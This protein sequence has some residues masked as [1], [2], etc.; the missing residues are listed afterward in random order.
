MS[1]V[2][3]TP[4][5]STHTVV[6]DLRDA[7]AVTAAVS[8]VQPSLVVHAAYARDEASI[9]AATQH[10]VDAAHGVGA[11]VLYVS[12]DAVF[13]G[14][15]IAR[16]E[17]ADPDPV[18]DY[19]RWKARAERIVSGGS[20]TAAIVRLPLIVSVEPDDPVVDRIRSTGAR[21]EQTA[22][23]QDETRQPALAAEM[24]EAVWGIA[25]LEPA[26]RAGPWHLPGPE[27]LSRY[28][29]ARR[30]VTTL[31]LDAD[32]IVAER[33]PPDAERPRHLKLRDGRARRR[34][35]WSPSRILS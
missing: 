19:G 2:H 7:G 30:V 31:G 3:R 20:Q 23:F 9:V 33:T 34:L 29:I 28:E 26:E 24:A 13:C 15:G 16:D 14:D 18:W 4:V 1:I 11:D 8:N 10:V 21:G 12:T 22:W 5:S 17:D 6:A 25:S 27:S 35:G 32:A